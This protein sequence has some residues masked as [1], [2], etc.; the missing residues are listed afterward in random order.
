MT[1]KA[2]LERA[3]RSSQPHKVYN[4]AAQ[5]FVG[6]SWNLAEQTTKVNALGPLNLLESILS[7]DPTIRMYQ[8]STSEM[9]GKVVE[10]PQTENT[11]F[12]P[13]SP[14]AVSKQYGHW[15]SKN[16]RESYNLYVCNGILFNHESERRGKEF[17]TRKITDGVARIA[18]GKQSHITLGNL[19]SRRDWGYAPDYVEAMWMM[20]Q[21]DKE[22]FE[23]EKVGD[24]II[25]TGTNH[26]I[27]DFLDLAFNEIDIKDWSPYVKQDARFMR[28]AEVDILI[29]DNTKAQEVL[30]WKPKVS[31]GELVKRMVKNDLRLVA[32]ENF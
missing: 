30:G 16:F 20:L 12:Y 8:A 23:K 28:P 25:S 27:K 2:S 32:S 6:A 21:Q 22:C 11:P 24:F 15:I 9:F 17:V 13:R 29:G 10:T 19:D 18:H 5:S 14:Y 4:L 26:S 1:D 3:L 31:F 7:I